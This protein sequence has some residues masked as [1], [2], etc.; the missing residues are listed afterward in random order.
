MLAP[1]AHHEVVAPAAGGDGAAL[2]VHAADHDDQV[3]VRVPL[4]PSHVAVRPLR[5]VVRVLVLRVIDLLHMLQPQ[6]CC[7]STI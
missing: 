7:D 5:T 6:T 4:P 3:H 2:G 1:P